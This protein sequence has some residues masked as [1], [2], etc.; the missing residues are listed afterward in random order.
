MDASATPP[1]ADLGG[2]FA[3]G[4]AYEAQ[5]AELCDM[6]FP[7]DQVEAAMRAAFNNA[8]R[9]V[10]YLF[11]G[12]PD[13]VVPPAGAGGAAAMTGVTGGAAAGGGNGGAAPAA[14]VPQTGA[15]NMFGGNP[16]AAAAGAGGG[17]GGGG[18]DGD[19]PL[20]P[21][22]NLPQFAMIRAMVQTQVGRGRCRRWNLRV[23]HSPPLFALC[24]PS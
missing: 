13:N 20:G 22:R 9:A 4:D 8:N 19:D 2:D 15:F 12:I 24:L 6:G 23:P 14:D 10:D 11:N 16:A 21:L 17:G 1:T 7:R 18:G 3:S 5:V